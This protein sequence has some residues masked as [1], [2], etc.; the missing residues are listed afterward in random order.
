M[1]EIFRGQINVLFS[2]EETYRFPP[3]TRPQV[4]WPPLKGKVTL[5]THKFHEFESKTYGK[6]NF[7][8]RFFSVLTL[9]R[10]IL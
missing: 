5:G 6:S 8:M 10:D 7:R 9:L 4:S 3:H 1:F 2:V